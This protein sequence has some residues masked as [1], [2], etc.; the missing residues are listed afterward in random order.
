MPTLSVTTVID[1][2][3]PHVWAV[4]R[5]F[6][7]PSAWYPMALAADG[8]GSPPDPAQAGI[9]RVVAPGGALLRE[10]LVE[11]DDTGCRYT[12]EVLDLER[13][14]C[15]LQLTGP[16]LATVRVESII[17][18]TMARVVWSVRYDYAEDGADAARD[19]VRRLERDM[20]RP[21]LRELRRRLSH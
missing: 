6:R 8:T 19:Q 5:D 17:G 9:R 1:R 2:P 14:P 18:G 11:H 10:R 20:F 16:C 21:A 7:D 15:G 3:A 12:Y 13:Q 4:L